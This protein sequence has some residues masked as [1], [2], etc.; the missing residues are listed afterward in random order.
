MRVLILCAGEGSRWNNYTGVPKHRVIVEG[1]VLIERTISQFLKYTD[2]IVVVTNSES[3]IFPGTSL[4]LANKDEN[5]KDMDKFLSSHEQWSDTKTI[6]VYG[7]V[8]FTD[9]TV[10]TIATNSRPWCFYLRENGSLITGKPWGEIFGF[11]FDSQFNET[12]LQTIKNTLSERIDTNTSNPAGWTL[13]L[14]LLGV[15]NITEIFT[16]RNS[17][18]YINI[19]DWTEDFDFPHD[20]DIWN[21]FRALSF[22]GV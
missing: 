19:D 11:S 21:G 17:F 12:M 4:Y 8:Y 16:G 15:Q 3:D 6:I 5:F 22:S 2:D 18:A 20:L 1:K 7:D 13:L 10:E 14:S 9:E